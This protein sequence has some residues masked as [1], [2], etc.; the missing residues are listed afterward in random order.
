MT[1]AR[2]VKELEW[3]D[4][5]VKSE[6]TWIWRYGAVRLPCYDMDPDHLCTS[7]QFWASV[8]ERPQQRRS[9]LRWR[10][11]RGQ[12]TTMNS[13][14]LQITAIGVRNLRAS[15]HSVITP[16]ADF[17]SQWLT[18]TFRPVLWNSQAPPF[19]AFFKNCLASTVRSFDELLGHGQPTFLCP[20]A[21]RWL[22]LVDDEDFD[23]DGITA[24][25]R[26]EDLLFRNEV[27]KQCR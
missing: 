11:T 13:D 18:K 26:G 5:A 6:V 15:L 21:P 2:K 4:S 22:Y 8:C 1:C 27:S 24:L 17:T 7:S 16:E 14:S 3:W 12:G 25:P 23:L 20:T 10:N 9:Y 19:S